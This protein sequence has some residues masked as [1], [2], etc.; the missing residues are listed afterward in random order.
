[1]TCLCTI[2]L[3]PCQRLLSPDVPS[4][5]S[6]A[7]Q[8]REQESE[9]PGLAS[10]LRMPDAGIQLPCVAINL[11]ELC[12]GLVAFR[13]FRGMS[14]GLFFLHCWRT[15][16]PFTHDSRVGIMMWDHPS[17]ACLSSTV[18]R[19]QGLLSHWTLTMLY[20]ESIILRPTMTSDKLLF[21]Q[22]ERV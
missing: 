7:T 12:E 6:R 13:T 9:A 3:P 21:F 15:C 2:L 19:G 16:T 8:A 4:I 14:S 17:H 5:N 18:R 1:M 22:Q 10:G 11:H 20:Y